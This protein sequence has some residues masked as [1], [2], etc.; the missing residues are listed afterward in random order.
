MLCNNDIYLDFA[1]V[2]RDIMHHLHRTQRP[3][4]NRGSTLLEMLTVLVVIGVLTSLAAP[5]L[6]GQI[7]RMKTHAVLN[8]L[9]GNVSYARMSAV[10][11]GHSA[12]VRF[13]WNADKSCV[14]SYDIV[15]LTSPERIIKKVAVSAE[16]RGVCLGM[17][18]A[19]NR[20]IF[21][22]RG[23]PRTVA[24][25]SFYAARGVARDSMRLSQAGR[26]LRFP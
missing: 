10:R 13:T 21:N 4:R 22:S 11:A 25:R 19:N 18:N 24:A 20:L 26:L 14:T 1:I 9:A 2:I 6:A 3:L 5:S 12:E 17:N 7:A 15:E 23:V 16:T 8:A